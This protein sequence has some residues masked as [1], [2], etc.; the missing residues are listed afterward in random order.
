MYLYA[1]SNGFDYVLGAPVG[2]FIGGYMFK[3]VGSIGSFKLLTVIAFI[4]CATQIVVNYYIDRRSKN[5]QLKNVVY[6]EVQTRDDKNIEQ[7]IAETS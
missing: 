6:S 3:N 4:T 2:S 5:G 1:P 7:E